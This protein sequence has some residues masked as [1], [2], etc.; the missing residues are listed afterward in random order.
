MQIGH[1]KKIKTAKTMERITIIKL[2]QDIE[3]VQEAIVNLDNEDAL[4]LLM[5]IKEDLEIFLLTN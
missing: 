5:D 4:K 1:K 3:Q 2:I